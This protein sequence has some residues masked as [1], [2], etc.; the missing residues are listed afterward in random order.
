VKQVPESL[1]YDVAIIGAGPSGLTAGIAAAQAG[2]SVLVCERMAQPGIKLLATGGG[3]CNLTNTDSAEAFMAAF[4]RQG[5]FMQP[6]LAAMDDTGLREFFRRLGLETVCEDGFHVYPASHRAAD[7]LAALRKQ[8]DRLGVRLL[9][10]ATAGEI[11]LAAERATRVCGLA[12]SKGQISAPRVILAAGGKSWPALGSD[13]SGFALAEAVGHEI[14]PPTPALVPLKCRE[15]W[16]ARCAGIS[17][18]RARIWI[19]LRGHSKAGLTGDLL[20]TH[21]GISGPVVLDL[22]GQVMTLLN[23]GQ[24]RGTDGTGKNGGA[25]PKHRCLGVCAQQESAPPSQ[26]Q[27]RL[28]VAPSIV[29]AC[30]G[31]ACVP[32]QVSLRPEWSGREWQKLF[33][34]WATRLGSRSFGSLLAGEVPARLA[35]QLCQLARIDGRQQA[36]QVDR[37]QRSELAGLLSSL[38]LSVVGC[39]GFEKSMVTRGGVS[40]KQ[41]DPHSLQSKLIA[42][43]YFAGEVLDLDGPCGGYNLQWAFSSGYLAGKSATV[44][45]G[46]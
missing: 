45:C 44:D 20:F 27:Q 26:Q 11:V 4:G 15:A 21:N 10:G 24:N 16:V 8:C 28:G 19:D 30:S 35:E 2:A 32:I 17:I 43:L 41:V 22:S 6:A 23:E 3:R 9:S 39:E 13:G 25:T 46:D 1:S 29:A 12:T 5:R 33:D 7:V 38:P 37:L 34:D 36:A 40:L 14:V 18:S 42:G 31:S